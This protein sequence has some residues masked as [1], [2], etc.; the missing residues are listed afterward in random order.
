MSV[1]DKFQY[2]FHFDSSTNRHQLVLGNGYIEGG[3]L[4]G[5][6]R[7]FVSSV[8]HT[9]CGPEVVFDFISY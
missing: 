6:L 9:D 5:F 2:F 1:L 4:D 3:E 7:E 8:N